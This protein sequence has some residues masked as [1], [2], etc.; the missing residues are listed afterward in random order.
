M[1]DGMIV[2]SRKRQEGK[3][4]ELIYRAK[5]TGA[6]IISHNKRSVKNVI[7]LAEKLNLTIEKPM[8]YNDLIN[9]L[10]GTNKIYLIDDV[11]FFLKCII[12][13]NIIGVAITN[14]N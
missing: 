11:D 3:T 7:E 5:E 14:N 2:I 1:N 10:E 9:N 4:T 12:N 6:T 8:T 13:Q